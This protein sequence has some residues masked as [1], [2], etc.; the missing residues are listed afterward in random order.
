MPTLH[1]LELA[2]GRGTIRYACVSRIGEYPNDPDHENQDAHV[3]L[4]FLLDYTD[5]LADAA[6]PQDESEK[7]SE[8]A[9]F[10]VFDGHGAKGHV[11]SAYC[12]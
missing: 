12:R 5:G 1:E 7:P 11:V 2:G 4:P 10:G 3:E 8:C 6:H 9:L